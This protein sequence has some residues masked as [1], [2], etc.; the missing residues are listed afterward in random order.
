MKTPDN[1]DGPEIKVELKDTKLD[2]A[3]LSS[4][5][6]GLL[7]KNLPG[8]NVAVYQKN[9][10]LDGPLSETMLSRLKANSYN[11]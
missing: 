3:Q 1:Y 7:A 9:E 5:V 10:D 6:D 8:K 4:F 2:P 11:L